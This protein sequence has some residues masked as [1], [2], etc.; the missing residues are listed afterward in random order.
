M[1]DLNT[2][3]KIR[4]QRWLEAQPYQLRRL[5][6]DGSPSRMADARYAFSTEE[7]AVEFVA[8][9]RRLNPSKTCR[10]ALNGVEV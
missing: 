5:N 9:V 8:N 10:F 2:L 3:A 6:K 7:A 4:R 1:R